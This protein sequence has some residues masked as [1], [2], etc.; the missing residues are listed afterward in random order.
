MS[1]E[2]E[3]ADGP[4]VDNR[5][6]DRRQNSIAYLTRN[7]LRSLISDAVKEVHVPVLTEDEIRWVRLAIQSEA[8]RAEWRA[9]VVKHSTLVL[10]GLFIGWLATHAFDIMAGVVDYFRANPK[11][12]VVK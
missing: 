6:F 8:K 7:D 5:K 1:E 4:N 2:R 11:P 10:V 9:A 3:F 12:P